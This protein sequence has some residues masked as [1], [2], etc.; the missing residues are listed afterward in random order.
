MKFIQRLMF[1]LLVVQVTSGFYVPA[2][3]D[4][5]FVRK[6]VL[7]FSLTKGF[8][9]NSIV[10]GN[11]FFMEAG[12]KKGFDVD[13]T[14]D[15]GVFTKEGLLPYAAVVWLNTT[16]DVLNEQQQEAFQLYIRSGGNYVG[17]HAASDTEFDWPW[18]NSLVGGYF[19]SHPGPKNVQD[20]K[21]IKMDKQFPAVSHLPD[22][23]YHKDEF[24][25]FKSLK[26]DSI[27]ILLRIDESSYS[28]GKMGAFHPMSWYHYF[29]GGRS[30]YSA[31]GHTGESFSD[32]LLSEHFLRG[33][34]WAMGDLR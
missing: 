34:L 20:G 13:T 16:G 30:F 12:R 23:F 7:V 15:A 18:Y 11:A 21:V 26:R 8:H 28:G 10:Q 2:R 33:L 31:F 24:Y 4:G 19:A 6:R 3:H 5:G 29:E 9:H 14:T 17:I 1:C 32:P 27:H 22:S 25:D